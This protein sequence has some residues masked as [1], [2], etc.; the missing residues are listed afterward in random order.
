MQ[1][2]RSPTTFWHYM[3]QFILKNYYG[4]VSNTTNI[5]SPD[6]QLVGGRDEKE[7][8]IEVRTEDHADWVTVCDDLWNDVN[9]KVVCKQLGYEGKLRSRSHKMLSWSHSF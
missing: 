2:Q 7:G 6:I 3:P 8:R 4:Q 5:I 9:A 1:C